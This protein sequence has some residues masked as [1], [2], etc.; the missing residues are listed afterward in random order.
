MKYD[1]LL[2]FSGGIAAVRRGGK[3]GFTNRRH[4]V[5]IPFVYDNLYQ[6]HRDGN[7]VWF[8]NNR[9]NICKKGKW[10]YIDSRGVERIPFVYD[11][12]HN[13][14]DGLAT[15]ELN[16]QKVIIDV[17]G[18]VV[19]SN[20]EKYDTV[21]YWQDNLL[22]VSRNNKYGIVN[23]SGKVLVQLIYSWEDI[24]TCRQI[25]WQLKGDGGS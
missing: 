10:G 17:T 9:I 3:W 21:W 5:V 24:I 4:E 18:K 1:E 6:Y 8:F 20:E 7:K 12:A 15:V 23:A 16:G 2:I 14:D 25:L 22:A 11:C 19:F 13:F